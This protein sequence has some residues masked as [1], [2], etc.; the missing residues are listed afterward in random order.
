[1]IRA[2]RIVLA[3]LLPLFFTQGISA[4]GFDEV[5]MVVHSVA[6]DVK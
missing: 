3:G 6:G 4:Q 2:L 5:E 1:M